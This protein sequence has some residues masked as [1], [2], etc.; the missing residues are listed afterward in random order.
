MSVFVTIE[1]VFNDGEVLLNALRKLYPA[2]ERG[3]DIKLLNY[4]DM[5][6][7]RTA[8]IVIRKKYLGNS[9]YSSD[10]GFKYDKASETYKL[11]YDEY[12][13]RTGRFDFDKLEHLYTEEKII[14]ELKLEGY[15]IVENQRVNNKTVTLL[16][17]RYK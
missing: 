1:T 13:R 5:P 3:R 16:V 2:V 6:S 15:K 11:I 9:R 8:D 4:I 14:K 17:E 7:G 10:I 12:D